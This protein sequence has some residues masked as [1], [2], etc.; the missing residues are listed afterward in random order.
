MMNKMLEQPGVKTIGG[1]PGAPGGLMAQQSS[2]M[3]G[4][5]LIHQSKSVQRPAV[6]SN[7]S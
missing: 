4:N 2:I 1:G 5:S 6:K 3:T 7:E